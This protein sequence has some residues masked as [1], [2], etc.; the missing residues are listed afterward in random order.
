MTTGAF[1]STVKRGGTGC[2]YCAGK[3]VDPA[4]ARKVMLRAGLDPL[5]PYE[6]ADKPWKCQCL[7]CFKV[8]TPAYSAIGQGQ[9]G[10][11][12]C[13]GKKVDPQDAISLFLENNLKPLEPFEN[14]EKKWKSECMK[15]GRIVYPKHHMIKSRSGGCKYCS[16]KGMDFIKGKPYCSRCYFVDAHD[17]P[18]NKCKDGGGGHFRKKKENKVILLPLDNNRTPP[19]TD[20]RRLRDFYHNWTNSILQQVKRKF[21]K[22]THVLFRI[23]SMTHSF[24]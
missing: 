6:K 9:S 24:Q 2:V 21:W 7:T 14:T 20:D 10:C 18:A 23:S 5:E 19:P 16:T 1:Y 15:C 11:V 12:Y 4:E 17:C 3:K 22:I 8:V 13:A